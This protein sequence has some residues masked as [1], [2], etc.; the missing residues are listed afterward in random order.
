MKKIIV[1]LENIV[2]E[3]R[4]E[5][6]VT[7]VLSGVNLTVHE[8]DFTA[9]RGK[10]GSGKSTLMHIIGMLDVPT[11]GT[12]HFDG[13]KVNHLGE[14]SLAFIRNKEIGF[15]FQQFN[16]LSRASA[17]ENVIL[18]ATYAGTSERARIEKAK[19]LLIR[20][21]MEKEIY[22]R[23]NQMSGGQQ[24]RVAIARALMNDPKLILADEP[25]GNLDTHSGEAVMKVLKELNKEG[26]T[27]VLITHEEDIA[28]QARKI[29]R[30]VEGK[31]LE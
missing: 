2:K 11:S 16:L 29:I 22:K 6:V 18:P 13:K 15:V 28:R 1:K 5:D 9:I 23:P 27:I 4:T 19:N 14:D 21:E 7:S 17:L 24:Q 30:L 26:R 10:S 3:Y 12:Y 20:L 31:I 8:G 25:T